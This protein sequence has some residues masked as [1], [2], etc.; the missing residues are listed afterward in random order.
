MNFDGRLQNTR[1][2]GVV[3]VNH[4]MNPM[5]IENVMQEHHFSLKRYLATSRSNVNTP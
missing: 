5:L 1:N 4:I 2:E 3:P